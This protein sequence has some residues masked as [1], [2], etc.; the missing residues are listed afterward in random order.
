MRHPAVQQVWGTE[1]NSLVP[2]IGAG[3]QTPGRCPRKASAWVKVGAAQNRACSVGGRG[4]VMQ[5]EDGLPR[6]EP[7]LWVGPLE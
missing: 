3:S 7:P 4:K 1:D 5:S 6:L 2:H